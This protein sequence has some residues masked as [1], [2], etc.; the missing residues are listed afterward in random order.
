MVNE[1]LNYSE[2]NYYLYGEAML[3]PPG[4]KGS[5]NV[6]HVFSCCLSDWIITMMHYV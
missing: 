1:K 5:V 2:S 6:F 4:S 3:I